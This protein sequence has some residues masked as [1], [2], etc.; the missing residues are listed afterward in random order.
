MAAA[1]KGRSYE[2]KNLWNTEILVENRWAGG[3]YGF[4]ETRR[5]I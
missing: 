4:E 1:R 2:V 5:N 3:V